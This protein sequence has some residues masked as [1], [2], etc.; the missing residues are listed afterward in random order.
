MIEYLSRIK[1]PSELKEDDAGVDILKVI[2]TLNQIRFMLK[3]R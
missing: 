2:P 1:S 3:K